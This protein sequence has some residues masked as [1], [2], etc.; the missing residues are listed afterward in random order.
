VAGLVVAVAAAAF[1][2]WRSW[3][4]THFY[5]THF[6]VRGRLPEGWKSH[7]YPGSLGFS[8]TVRHEHGSGTK[9][10]AWMKI[11]SSDPEGILERYRSR[12]PPT[13]KVSEVTIDTQPALLVESTGRQAYYV[14]NARGDLIYF[15]F[16]EETPADEAAEF[17]ADLRFLG[18]RPVDPDARYTLRGQVTMITGNCMPP[19]KCK[20]K[21]VQREIVI[22]GA[23]PDLKPGEPIARIQTDEDG[24][25]RL[26]LPPGRYHL[27][28]I[29][30]GKEWCTRGGTYGACGVRIIDRDIETSL[31]ID[32]ASH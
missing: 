29:E 4:S 24:D 14:K 6:L 10:A 5:S 18:G 16:E 21:E 1:G 26:A 8:R 7:E 25:F 13:H 12:P 23:G 15:Y 31:L 28:V 2:A 9:N 30:D 19:H 3:S 22:R 17:M 32:R 27:F 11:V 20:P